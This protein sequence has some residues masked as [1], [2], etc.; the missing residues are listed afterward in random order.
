[1][2]RRAPFGRVCPGIAAYP[3]ADRSYCL[4]F[5]LWPVHGVPDSSGWVPGVF[6]NSVPAAVPSSSYCVPGLPSERGTS[7]DPHPTRRHAAP[8]VSRGMGRGSPG[9]V[10]C[11][12][13]GLGFFFGFI[14]TFSDRF[15]IFALVSSVG[16]GC[17]GETR[18]GRPK[19]LP[20]GGRRGSPTAREP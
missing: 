7:Q 19:C 20:F 16:S 13:A 10:G 18:R 8:G 12:V 2:P 4:V 11:C 1:M 15:S 9:W 5:C 14:C 17:R 3:H 6:A